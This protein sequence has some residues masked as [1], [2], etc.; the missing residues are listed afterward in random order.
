MN[1]RAKRAFLITMSF[2]VIVILSFLLHFYFS[3][4][5]NPVVRVLE[6]R[7]V[8]Q[9]YVNRHDE[10]FKVIRSSYDYK[11]GEFSFQV[12]P[13]HQPDLTFVTTREETSRIDQ[14]SRTQAIN[15]LRTVLTEGLSSD[16]ALLANLVNVSEELTSPHVLE[17][18]VQER[19]RVNSH[20]VSFSWD[21]Q[22]IDEQAVNDALKII[23]VAIAERLDVPVGSLKIRVTVYDGTNYH[24]SEIIMTE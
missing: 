18:D 24:F 14:Y 8:I 20:V 21:V 16:I 17:K 6:S 7:A 22:I 15:Y 3:F 4:S 13:S 11:R 9:F 10:D 5:G 23:E 2:L 19:L 12:A 1:S